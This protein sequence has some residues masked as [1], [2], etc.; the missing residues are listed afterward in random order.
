M[1]D[2]VNEQLDALYA[3]LPTIDCQGHCW[4]SCGPI[5]MSSA[6]QW[7]I[8][9]AGVF[10]P[11]RSFTRD[12]PSTCT[13]LTAFRQCSVYDVR[14]LICR[15]W[16]LTKRLPCAYGCR[17]SR[18]LTE[19]EAYELLARAYDI[20]GQQALAHYA[21]LAASPEHQKLMTTLR[22]QLDI[23]AEVIVSKVNRRR[24]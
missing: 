9:R 5:D 19:P 6:E 3:E 1:T 23:D 18:W 13:A 17:P 2:D 20:S 10:I 22:D 7:R 14:P 8:R 16:G 12:G 11:L 15:I 4:D 24:P 21:R